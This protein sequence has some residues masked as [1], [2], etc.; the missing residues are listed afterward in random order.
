MTL[1]NVATLKPKCWSLQLVRWSLSISHSQLSLVS[2]NSCCHVHTLSLSLS[3]WPVCQW[4]HWTMTG[5]SEERGWLVST[6]QVIWLKESVPRQVDKKSGVLRKTEGPETLEEEIGVWNSQGGGKDK[7]LFLFF[8]FSSAFLSLIHTKRFCFV[9]F[10]FPLKS[11][12]NDYIT[13]NS[14]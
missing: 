4:T 8:F 13:N 2:R 1:G 9:L 12:T 7:R 6:K 3:P 14:V 11:R 10:C 5:V